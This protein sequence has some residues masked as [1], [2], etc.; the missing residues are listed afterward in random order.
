[1]QFRDFL[2][3]QQAVHRRPYDFDRRVTLQHMRNQFP[4]QGG[5]IHD[6]YAD[7]L[8][9]PTTSSA[10]FLVKCET[11][12]GTFRIKTTVPSPRIEA[13]LT[14]SDDT[15]RSSNDLM[16]SSSSPIRPS[17]TSPNFRLPTPIVSTKCRFFCE[18][19]DEDSV[20]NNSCSRTTLRTWSRN[21][22]IW[23]PSI[24]WIAES[25]V[26]VISSTASS[27]TA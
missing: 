19:V 24:S 1:M 11:T 8:F 27:G 7:A 16:T 26:R 13:P 4:H 23:R 22:R 20:A 12:A 5:I 2:Q 9:H 17:T 15:R 21:R 6:Q 18:E 14:K 10:R 3:P 25:G